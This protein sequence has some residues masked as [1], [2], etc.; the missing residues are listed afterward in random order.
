MVASHQLPWQQDSG[1]VP[2]GEHYIICCS[3]CSAVMT[4]CFLCF[5]VCVPFLLFSLG[6]DPKLDL[7]QLP[8]FVSNLN[9]SRPY[10]TPQTLESDHSSTD[11]KSVSSPSMDKENCLTLSPERTQDPLQDGLGTPGMER[12]RCG[13]LLSLALSA[14]SQSSQSSSKKRSGDRYQ[15]TP[16]LEMV[17]SGCQAALQFVGVKDELPGSMIK[18]GWSHYFLVLVT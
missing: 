14:R 7:S 12:R 16:S 5:Q 3:P 8:T 18:T 11:N 4:S 13:F 2:A 1:S 15:T 10:S 17:L 6:V 9:T